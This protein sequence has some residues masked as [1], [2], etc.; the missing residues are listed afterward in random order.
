MTRILALLLV[1][2]PAV[3]AEAPLRV[4]ATLVPWV[5]VEWEP[6]MA[7]VVLQHTTEADVRVGDV[8]VA[9][10]SDRWVVTDPGLAPEVRAVAELRA[11]EDAN[12]VRETMRRRR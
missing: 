9:A 12:V 11:R 4:S 5:L 2:W 6:G 1:A 8:D 7:R 3:A 10:Q